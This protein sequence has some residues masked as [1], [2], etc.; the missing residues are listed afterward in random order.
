[1]FVVLKKLLTDTNLEYD[2]E[3]RH[4]L[5]FITSTIKFLETPSLKFELIYICNN[6]NIMSFYSELPVI[7]Y[8]DF[9]QLM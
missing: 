9:T 8:P 1:M 7:E 2:M 5:G 3:L 6:F 4:P